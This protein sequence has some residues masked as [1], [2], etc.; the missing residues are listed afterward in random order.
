MNNPPKV[1][2]A[3]LV[4][5]FHTHPKV[6]FMGRYIGGEPTPSTTGRNKDTD[7]KYVGLPGLVVAEV[8]G[9]LVITPYGPNRRGSDPDNALPPDLVPGYPGNSADT[10]GCPP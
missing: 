4:G 6:Y 9:K 1:R 3:L 7:I 2:G 5:R 10:R 8:N